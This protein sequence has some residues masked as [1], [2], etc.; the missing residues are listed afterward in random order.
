MNKMTLAIGGAALLMACSGEN[1]NA[2]DSWIS[3][4]ADTIKRPEFSEL[5]AC[6]VADAEKQIEA[7]LDDNSLPRNRLIDLTNKAADALAS[8]SPGPFERR[9]RYFYLGG[10]LPKHYDFRLTSEELQTRECQD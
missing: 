8:G 10:D 6:V 3:G 5:Y 2:G 9:L 4:P 1:A 7:N